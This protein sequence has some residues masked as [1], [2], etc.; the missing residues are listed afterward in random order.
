MWKF[1]PEAGTRVTTLESGE[2]Q[3]DLLRPGP[4]AAP[5]RERTR[6]M[7][8]EKTPWPGV[9]RIWLLNVTKPPMDDVQ[10]RR[11]I[12]YA[13]DKDAFLATV[14][15]GIGA[16]GLRAAHRGDARRPRA[17]ARP[18]PFDRG[19]GQGPAR[20]GRLAAGRRRHPHQGRPAARDRPQRHRVRRRRR[21]DGAAHPVLAAR[22]RHRRQDQGPGAA[23]LVRGQL[24]LRHPRAGHVPALHRSRRPLLA[25]P[26]ARWSAPTSTGRA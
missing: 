24:S 6:R 21:S 12:N 8:I 13:V 23:A 22:G 16:E 17:D 25:L 10:V 7:R 2:T 19:Q 1:I 3:G 5:P 26:L 14:Y 11:A 15:K 20:R 18:I 9:P 4:V